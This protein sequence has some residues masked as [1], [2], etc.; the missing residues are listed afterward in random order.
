VSDNSSNS[1]V[2]ALRPRDARSRIDLPGASEA[3]VPTHGQSGLVAH[4]LQTSPELLATPRT[5]HHRPSVALA[6][7]VR[8]RRARPGSS[9]VRHRSDPEYVAHQLEQHR[10]IV[11]MG[12]GFAQQL[13][14]R[15]SLPMASQDERVRRAMHEL[16]YLGIRIVE[17]RPVHVPRDKH[18][19]RK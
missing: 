1:A 8:T 14:S 19:R 12:G 17:R 4:R 6:G 15:R 7:S 16:V 3:G 9:P 5:A 10:V 11:Q 18:V 13:G 2:D